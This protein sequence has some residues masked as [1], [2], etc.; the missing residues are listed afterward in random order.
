MSAAARLLDRLEGVR[1]VGTARWMARCPAHE[2]RSA[3]L[4]IRD[5]DGR[6]L[7]CC[8]AGCSASDVVEALGLKLADLFD[9]PIAHHIS[10]MASPI[11]AYVNPAEVLR[12]LAHE[13]V[14]LVLISERLRVEPR[15]TDEMRSRLD[16][17]AG[18]IN[19]ALS[20]INVPEAPE[21]RRIRRGAVRVP[22]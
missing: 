14:V 10:G 9:A 1:S 18:R 6:V 3:S 19:G 20:L 15:L 11:R 17:A 12:D 2:D 7:I 13:A 4:S 5:A 21:M 16:L 22:A 8:H